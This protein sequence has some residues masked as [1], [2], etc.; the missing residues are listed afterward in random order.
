MCYF[1][2]PQP[3]AIFISFRPRQQDADMARRGVAARSLRSACMYSTSLSKD[4]GRLRSAS[5]TGGARRGPPRSQQQGS[6]P[7]RRRRCGERGTG[8]AAS[9]R[10]P[11]RCGTDATRRRTPGAGPS[12]SCRRRRRCSRPR[13]A[14]RLDKGHDGSEE[15]IGAWSTAAAA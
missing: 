6:P 12:A 5:S 1:H 7:Q 13:R 8:I 3:C 10:A 2:K 14:I 9:L 11:R 15:S 4:S